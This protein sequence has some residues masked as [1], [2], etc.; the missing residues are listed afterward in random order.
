MIS[1]IRRYSDTRLSSLHVNYDLCKIIISETSKFE[2][3]IYE[4]TNSIF[5][6]FPCLF[7]CLFCFLPVNKILNIN[8]FMNIYRAENLFR[9][10]SNEVGFPK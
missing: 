5:I 9:L 8:Q 2:A 3:N 10:T 7:P 1:E 6:A 4:A